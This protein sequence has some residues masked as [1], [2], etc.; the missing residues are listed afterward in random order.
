MSSLYVLRFGYLRKSDSTG[1]VVLIFLSKQ[2]RKDR[3]ISVSDETVH[4]GMQEDV[5]TLRPVS[6]HQRFIFA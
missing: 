1:R 3:P 4:R 6:V 5:N 2:D